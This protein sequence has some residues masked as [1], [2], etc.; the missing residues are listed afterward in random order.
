VNL[1]RTEKQNNLESKSRGKRKYNLTRLY[2]FQSCCDF[3][4]S[5]RDFTRSWSPNTVTD[6]AF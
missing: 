1:D 4:R 2:R 3:R 6:Y 5:M